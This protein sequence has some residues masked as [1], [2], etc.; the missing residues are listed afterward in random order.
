MPGF[1][2]G[3]GV[4]PVR[5]DV[6]PPHQKPDT[7]LTETEYQKFYGRVVR[8]LQKFMGAF[9]HLTRDKPV[10]SQT[11]RVYDTFTKRQTFHDGYHKALHDY[12]VASAMEFHKLASIGERE[13]NG[14]T[15]IVIGVGSKVPGT[16]AVKKLTQTLQ[17]SPIN[18][19]YHFLAKGKDLPPGYLNR[20]LIP[21]FEEVLMSEYGLDMTEASLTMKTLSAQ[22]GLRITSDITFERS[23]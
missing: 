2:R 21:H 19:C 18:L 10:P 1:N 13:V 5:P 14:H 9:R 4:N 3:G 17:L 11:F 6:Q 23:A 7:Q 12:K 16:E 8:A 22:V 20:A 15:E